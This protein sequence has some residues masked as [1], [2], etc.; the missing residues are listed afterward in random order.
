MCVCVCVCPHLLVLLV[1]CEPVDEAQSHLQLLIDAL[2]VL[3]HLDY[4]GAHICNVGRGDLGF[5]GCVC[6][7]VSVCVCV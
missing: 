5:L 6:V 7:C 1:V 3:L 2:L 4:L